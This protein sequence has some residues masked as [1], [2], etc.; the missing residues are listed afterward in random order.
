MDEQDFR[1]PGPKPDSREA[2]IVMLADAAE[3]L[4]RLVDTSQR[5]E[6][7]SAV[8]SIIM[9]RVFDGQLT[10]TMLTIHD[11]DLIQEAF[12]KNLLGSSHQR[13]RYKNTPTAQHDAQ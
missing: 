13:V 3:A 12:V 10:N 2:G 7:E 6:I 5:Q 8:H 11:L 9:D 4:S 1:Y